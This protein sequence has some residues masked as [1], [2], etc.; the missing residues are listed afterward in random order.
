MSRIERWS[1]LSGVLAVALWIV[2]IVLVTH[3]NPDYRSPPG[4]SSRFPRLRP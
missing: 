4:S 2:G 1:P 3:N